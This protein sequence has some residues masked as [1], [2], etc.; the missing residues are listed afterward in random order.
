[1]V[2]ISYQA[3]FDYYAASKLSEGG[4]S[5]NIANINN[6][7]KVYA[8]DYVTATDG[9]GIVHTA[10]EFGEEDFATGKRENLY[11]TN[12]LNEE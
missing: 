11:Q 6:T 12:A 7:H 8:A 3:P 1:M 10:P 2:G 9:T 4:K 5:D